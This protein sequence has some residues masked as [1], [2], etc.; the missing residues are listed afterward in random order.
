M[1]DFSEEDHWR[2]QFTLQKVNLFVHLCNTNYTSLDVWTAISTRYSGLFVSISSSPTIHKKV[3][4]PLVSSFLD[5]QISLDEFHKQAYIAMEPYKQKRL[6]G[7]P[8]LP[9]EVKEEHTQRRNH[10]IKHLMKEKYD[11]ARLLK[12][13]LPTEEECNAFH[14]LLQTTTTN[15]Q[16]YQLCMQL[17]QKCNTI[18][19]SSSETYHLLCPC[20]PKDTFHII[21]SQESCK[22]WFQ[23]I[24][25]LPSVY[26]TEMVDDG[27]YLHE[28]GPFRYAEDTYIISFHS[29]SERL[30]SNIIA[31]K[32]DHKISMLP[33]SLYQEL[34]N[35][36]Q[37]LSLPYHC[38]IQTLFQKV[39]SSFLESVTHIIRKKSSI[40]K[41]LEVLCLHPTRK[42]N[43]YIITAG[44]VEASIAI[45]TYLC[46]N[47]VKMHTL[48]HE[49][50]K[51]SLQSLLPG[52]DETVDVIFFIGISSGE[53]ISVP[54]QVPYVF[55][56]A[57]F[58]ECC[59]AFAKALPTVRKFIQRKRHKQFHW[60]LTNCSCNIIKSD[61][62]T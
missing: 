7:R 8:K 59:I 6:R 20:Q 32:N 48:P 47:Q 33:V 25:C 16:S 42:C 19:H 56:P 49:N 5:T 4:K 38:F 41:K 36:F 30:V 35:C 52:I 1:Q 34:I 12:E 17:F 10:Q 46:P 39:P 13:N 50:V 29:N 14:S 9:E 60:P 37:K 57:T 55:L 54:N 28:V 22:V 11:A 45:E 15:H 62:K 2:Y 58:Y 31:W 43:C 3:F 21:L 61:L 44:S 24:H 40:T 26:Q 23:T 53:V 51:E 27:T 18:F